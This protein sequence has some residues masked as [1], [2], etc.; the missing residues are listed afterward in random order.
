M[1]E[2]RAAAQA[3]TQ[4]AKGAGAK[5]AK[6]SEAKAASGQAAKAVAETA[7]VDAPAV[8]LLLS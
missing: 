5:A 6:G 2:Q 8:F 3:L 1:Q 4:T 7:K